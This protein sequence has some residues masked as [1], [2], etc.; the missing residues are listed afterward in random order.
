M[1]QG[2]KNFVDFILDSMNSEELI[3]AFVNAKSIKELEATFVERG[4]SVTPEDLAKIEEIKNRM[5][6]PGPSPYY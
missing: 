2:K 3:R 4:Y 6:S 5:G 1:A